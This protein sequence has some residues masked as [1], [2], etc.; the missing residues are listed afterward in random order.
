MLT[1]SAIHLK[2]SIHKKQSNDQINNQIQENQILRLNKF[3][4]ETMKHDIGDRNRFI[5]VI[6]IQIKTI[7]HF[8]FGFFSIIPTNNIQNDDQTKN[9]NMR[10]FL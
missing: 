2:I 5:L 3:L 4:F 9:S 6:I 1:F 8:E 10:K 7:T